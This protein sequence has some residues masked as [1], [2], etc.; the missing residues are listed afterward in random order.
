MSARQKIASDQSR[1]FARQKEG[2][3]REE[4]FFQQ[5]AFGEKDGKFFPTARWKLAAP[6]KDEAKA[7][8]GA[9]VPADLKAAMRE[10]K[11]ALL[12]R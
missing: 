12:K 8:D 3:K 6:A 2:L 9:H 4:A 11:S 1:A 7:K 10:S 5:N